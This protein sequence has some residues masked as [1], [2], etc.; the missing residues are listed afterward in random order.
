MK[1]TRTAHSVIGLNP[2]NKVVLVTGGTSGIGRET[3]RALAGLGCTVYELSRRAE[4]PEDA[5][6][7]QGNVTDAAAVSAA[8]ARIVE[9]AGR[10]D[11]VVNNAGFGISGAVEFTPA[12]EA[13]RLFDTDFFGM[14]NV[15]RAALPV[16][17]RQGSGRIVN[18]SSV[19]A[20]VP[21][22]FQAYYSAAKAAV[23][24]YSLA[25]AN[26]VRPYGVTVCAVMPGDIRTG[27]TAAREK[28]ALGDEEYG[29][30]I[31]RSV[32]VMER[33]EQNGMD[34]AAAGRFIARVVTKRGAK[35]LVAIGAKYKLFCL[36][37]RLLPVRLSN[38][39]VGLIYAR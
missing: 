18:I 16:M 33:D 31:S 23:S 15:N 32:A 13:R 30:R 26:E 19:A 36:L 5:I 28:S 6:H 22:P 27:F 2:M 37:I 24:T 9:E 25:L 10:L 17:R 34:P 12:E 20:P 8:V 3:V 38:W 14:V 39:I 35:P 7:I 21:I 29:G 4:G 11:A 1:N